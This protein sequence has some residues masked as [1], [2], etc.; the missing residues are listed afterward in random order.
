[1]ESVI[2]TLTEN[3]GF[4]ITIGANQQYGPMQARLTFAAST[5]EEAIK[6]IKEQL[7]ALSEIKKEE[8]PEATASPET[9]FE[10][11][12]KRLRDMRSQHRNNMAQMQGRNVPQMK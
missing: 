2:I 7:G 5:V 6:I 10:A 11:I 4:I 12:K 1:M 3:G 8:S 9:K